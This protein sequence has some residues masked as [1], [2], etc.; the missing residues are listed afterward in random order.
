MKK[1]SILRYQN[2]NFRHIFDYNK[3]L[4][5]GKFRAYPVSCTSGFS[6]PYENP[7]LA[8]S[9]SNL[10]QICV[11]Y[12]SRSLPLL[13]PVHILSFQALEYVQVQ[14]ELVNGLVPEPKT[15]VVMPTIVDSGAKSHVMLLRSLLQKNTIYPDRTVVQV[16]GGGTIDVKF[17]GSV[18][19]QSA[20]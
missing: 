5:T 19:L 2:T 9:E 15:G 17:R 18:H 13:R 11:Q 7:L 16:V 1:N 14:V 20:G 3:C 10:Y 6:V 8:P 12:A 4:L